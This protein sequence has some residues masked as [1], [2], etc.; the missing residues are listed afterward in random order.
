MIQGG[1]FEKGADFFSHIFLPSSSKLRS[2][3]YKITL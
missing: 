1:G 2:Q 3:K